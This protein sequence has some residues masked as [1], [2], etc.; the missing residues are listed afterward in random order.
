M[1]DKLKREWKTAAWGSA[2]IALELWDTVL[3]SQLD[4]VSPVIPDEYRWVLHT[5]IPV[6]FFLLRKWKDDAALQ[7]S[8]SKNPV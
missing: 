8:N 7:E 6:G 5:A 2:G 3:S 4:L 1:F